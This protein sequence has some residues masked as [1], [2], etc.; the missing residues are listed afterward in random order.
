MT[1]DIGALLYWIHQTFGVFIFFYM[2]GIIVVYSLMLLFAFF[3]LKHA[4]KLDKYLENDVNLKEVYSKPVSIIVPAYN[5]EQGIIATIHSLLTIEY[6]QYEIVVVN[7][8]STDETLKYVI[9]E[10]K[11]EEVFQT[12]PRHLQ[13]ERVRGM[14]RSTVHANIIV[15]DK[16]NGGKA[17]ALNVGINVSKY[18]YF[19]SIDGDSLLESKALL[20]VMK[21]IIAS[22][23]R[24]VAAGGSVRI[25]NGADIQF[26]KVL[27]TVVPRNPIVI[28]QI[29]EYLR[30]FY[31]GRIALSKFNLV[32]IISGAFSVFSK[33]FVIKVG[34]YSRKTIGEDMEL[35]V[36][37][38]RYLLKNKIKRTIEFIPDP[39]CW[40]EAPESLKDLRTQRRR[41]HQGLIG[42]LMMNRT[43]FLNPQYR[44][45]GMIS[46]PYFV[47]VELFGPIVE[48][49]G[50]IYVFLSFLV[51][52]IYME[53]AIILT[54]LFLIYGT[55]LSMFAVL[56]E[57]W[58]LKTYPRIRDTLKLMG[59]AFTENLWFRP[60]MTLYRLEGIWYYFRGKNDW[61][62]LKR[63]G[64]GKQQDK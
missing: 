37:L 22:N 46:F 30:A 41:W 61:G 40:T 44:Q 3:H 24:V 20:Q 53:S 14:Y 27:Q 51:G 28:M 4:L 54:L 35:V 26:G 47:F 5:E 25:A 59:Y 31:M 50:Y 9:E 1:M 58:S 23:G 49:L 29:I 7:D 64:F 43:M 6:P 45:I 12:I 13:T 48:F 15:I 18:P 2:I 39:I 8:G 38:H 32:L 11:M 52:N 16:D 57:A 42:S 62:K 19:C 17:D 36:R 33:D 63:T 10:F 55:M 21:P 56:L 60:L 34:G